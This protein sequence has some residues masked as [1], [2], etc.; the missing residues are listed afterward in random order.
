GCAG[1]VQQER[2]RLWV[3][4]DAPGF[5]PGDE[6]RGRARAA[7]FALQ[8]AEPLAV[9]VEEQPASQLPSPPEFGEDRLGPPE[10]RRDAASQA[11]PHADQSSPGRRTAMPSGPGTRFVPPCDGTKLAISRD[12]PV[13]ADLCRCTMA[14]FCGF[15]VGR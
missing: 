9:H 7:P 15:G 12:P 14:P 5:A 8:L 11:T 4:L 6:P 13:S 10:Q 2:A 1:R 3:D